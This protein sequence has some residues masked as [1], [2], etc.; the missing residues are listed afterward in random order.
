MAYSAGDLREH[1]RIQ[2]ETSAQN[3]NGYPVSAWDDLTDE[4]IAAGVRDVSNRDYYAALAANAL[5]TVTFIVRYMEGVDSRC[6][7]TWNGGTYS[8]TMVNGLGAKRDFMLIKT[9]R[10]N[11]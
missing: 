1:I 6:R 11:E 4:P 8:V 10:C 5:D 9:K 7:V 3:A 2:R